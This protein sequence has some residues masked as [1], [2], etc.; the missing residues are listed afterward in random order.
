MCNWLWHFGTWQL[1]LDYRYHKTKTRKAVNSREIISSFFPSP[2][3]HRV[4]NGGPVSGSPDT[5][6]PLTVCWMSNRRKSATVWWREAPLIQV[7][8]FFQIN[9]SHRSQVQKTSGSDAESAPVQLLLSLNKTST[10]S[11][12]RLWHWCHRF[13]RWE[14]TGEETSTYACAALYYGWFRFLFFILGSNNKD[15]CAAREER[16]GPELIRS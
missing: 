7:F 14:F 11:N 8:F 2:P 5:C 10:L 6:R 4:K 13:N 3:L 12:P 9:I 15:L 16:R 1:A